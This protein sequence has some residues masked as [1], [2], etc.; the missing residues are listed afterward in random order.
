MS[1]CTPLDKCACNAIADVNVVS[2]QYSHLISVNS[3]HKCSGSWELGIIIE[4]TSHRFWHTISPK[5][6]AL[7]VWLWIFA[8]SF[9]FSVRSWQDFVWNASLSAVNC[10]AFDLKWKHFWQ[11]DRC[12]LWFWLWFSKRVTVVWISSLSS[13]LEKSWVWCVKESEKI[14]LL[15]PNLSTHLIWLEL[16]LTFQF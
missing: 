2:T 7:Y 16:S 4:H 13:G 6:I 1:W 8:R 12:W 15:M 11:S 14:N 3:P 10:S 9:E 5:R